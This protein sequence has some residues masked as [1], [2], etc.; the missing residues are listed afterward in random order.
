MAFLESPRLPDDISYGATG[1]PAFA[2]TVVTTA[3]GHE[4]TNEPWS[5]ERGHWAIQYVRTHA[6]L[7]ALRAF[8]R[9]VGGKGRG[10][11][12]KDHSDYIVLAT[13]GR[14]GS[15][16]GDGTPGPMQLRQRE[17]VGAENYDLDI[18][19]PLTATIYRNAVAKTITT[20]YIIDMATGLL[21]W[22]ADDTEA[23]TGH[24]P[25]ASHVFTTATDMAAL[26]A[27]EKVY[28]TGVT[29]TA[30]ATLNAKAH[31]ISSKTGSGPYTWTISTA[32]T[33]L[34]ASSGT[35]GAYPQAADVLTWAGEF[36][37]AVRFDANEFTATMEAVGPGSR[38]YTIPNLPI[39]A[40][41]T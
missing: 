6:Q 41:R 30:A 10:F 9:V 37:K 11:R 3:G 33:G 25:G 15:A 7:K 8:F 31:T 17:T 5:Q 14:I 23:I 2:A 19:K 32:T 29:G 4:K 1:G 35:A 39:I 38:M 12:M 34:T 28:L 24:T 40:I 16:I 27:G 13:E 18:R 22:V 21:T 20:H 26:T 36:D